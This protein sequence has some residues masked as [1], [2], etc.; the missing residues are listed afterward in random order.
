MEYIILRDRVFFIGKISDLLELIKEKT[1]RY[2]TLQE[3]IEEE[4]PLD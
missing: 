2:K 4:A 1:I 3:M